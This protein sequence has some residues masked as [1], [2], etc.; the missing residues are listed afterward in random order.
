[1][2]EYNTPLST[3]TTAHLVFWAW[4]QLYFQALQ[5][6]HERKRGQLVLPLRGCR[7]RWRQPLRRR[8]KQQPRA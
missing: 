2:L 7:G 6:R 1:V 8:R 3:H 5:Q 4:R